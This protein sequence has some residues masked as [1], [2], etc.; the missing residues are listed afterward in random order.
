MR[1]AVTVVLVAVFSL[2]AAVATIDGAFAII[3]G[4]IPFLARVLPEVKPDGPSVLVGGIALF[5]FAAGVHWLGRSW[6][7]TANASEKWRLRW[8]VAV[9]SGV[10]LLFTAGIAIVGITH[11]VAWLATSEQPIISEGVSRRGNTGTHLKMIGIGMHGH[12]SANNEAFPSGGTFTPDGEGLHSWE[13]HILP[14]LT[15][16][17]QGIDMKRPWNAPENEKYFKC[18][19]P[20]FINAEYRTPPLEGANG[21][22]LSHF[23]ANSRVMSANKSM[24]LTEF[25]RGTSNTILVGE[26]NAGFRPWGHPVNFRDPATGLHGGP[27]TFGGPPKSNGTTF[28]MADGSIRVIGSG[29]DPAVLRN[30]ADPRAKE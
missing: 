4:W 19:I 5:V 2:I 26:V 8:T 17:R 7:G 3:F 28:L 15:Y 6:R 22:G 13:T 11:Q 29:V 20:E 9:V 23:A 27:H 24:K 16:S 18:V 30:L 1:T 10:I 14:W 21:F 25:T 12:A